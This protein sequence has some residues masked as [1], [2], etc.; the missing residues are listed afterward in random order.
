L[1][2]GS[3]ANF[4]NRLLWNGTSFGFDTTLAADT[5]YDFAPGG[6]GEFE[7]LGIDPGLGLD[8]QNTTAFITGLTFESAGDFTGTM[9]PVTTDVPEPASLTVLASGLLGLAA[10][11]RRR[12]ASGGRAPGRRLRA[13]GA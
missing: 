2:A 3:L 1:Q 6:V 11:R 7:V 10:I 5:V 9:T 13:R 12:T 8:P 4:E